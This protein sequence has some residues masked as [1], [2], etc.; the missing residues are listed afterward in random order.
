MITTSTP[1]RSRRAVAVV[2]CL[3]VVALGLSL[4][5][6]QA[7]DNPLARDDRPE[8]VAS[9]H[10]T[11]AKADSRHSRTP[12]SRATSKVF[13]TPTAKAQPGN[14]ASAVNQVRALGNG[15]AFS[16]IASG[17]GLSRPTRGT[18][19][20]PARSGVGKRVIYAKTAQRAWLVDAKNRVVRT[21]LVS[22]RM[23]QPDPGIYRVFSKSRHA[24]S[25]V[26]PPATMEYMVRF[27]RGTD[28]V[29]IGFHDLPLMR[30]GGFE[31]T[32]AQLGQPLSAGCVRQSRRDA[33]F[34]Y[35]WAPVGTTVVV[36][37]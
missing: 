11:T 2:G 32:E 35:R 1:A 34:L 20:L 9:S 19:A 29:N 6:C 30:S 23:N 12:T 4:T 8:I 15:L 3:V 7:V 14:L 36:L 31:Q 10:F 13:A 22:G 24:I 16:Q 37:G 21:Y 17:A 28:G 27:T 33:A 5:G 25:A 26:Q 18:T